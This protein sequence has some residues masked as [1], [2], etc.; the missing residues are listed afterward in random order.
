MPRS[1]AVFDDSDDNVDKS[2]ESWMSFA[3]DKARVATLTTR[4][5]A[6]VNN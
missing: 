3:N 1:N 2:C 6:A 5:W 4:E